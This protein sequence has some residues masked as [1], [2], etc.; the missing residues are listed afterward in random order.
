VG[1]AQGGVAEGLTVAGRSR[2]PTVPNCALRRWP[3]H[4][5]RCGL[6]PQGEKRKTW[7][8]FPLMPCGRPVASGPRSSSKRGDPSCCCGGSSRVSLFGF[9]AAPSS[10]LVGRSAWRLGDGGGK[11]RQNTLRWFRTWLPNRQ[12]CL[13]AEDLAAREAQEAAQVRRRVTAGRREASGG[14]GALGA[15][16]SGVAEGVMGRLM[17]WAFVA[18]AGLAMLALYR[19]WWPFGSSSTF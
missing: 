5:E 3:S 4:A 7:T 11:P 16:Q 6:S 17:F 13:A 1:A 8:E 15:A 19:G 18:L 10:R 12:G 2:A 14:A 9:G